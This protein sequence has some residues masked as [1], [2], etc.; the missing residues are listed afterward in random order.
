MHLEGVE[1]LAADQARAQEERTN[2]TANGAAV[3][4]VQAVT[5]EELLQR[6]I[7]M[8][9]YILNPWLREKEIGLVHAW[10]GIGKTF[11]TLNLAYAS[12]S[13]G[14]YL[15]WRA[16]RPRKVLYIDGEMPARTMQERLAAI[17]KGSETV[18]AF[19]PENL[20]FIC[21]DLQDAPLPNLSTREGQAA[22]APHVET[23]DLVIIDSI[24][25]LASY[26]EENAAE[27][28]LP[29]QAWALDLRRRGKTVVFV[30]HD[31]K[32]GQQ[33]GTSKREDILDV[34]IHLRRPSD[35]DPS[36]GARFEVH[37]AKARALY[38]QAV[39]PVEARL[40]VVN[41]QATWTMKTVA[42]ADLDRVAAILADGGKIN[43]IIEELGCSRA[44]AY[45]LKKQVLKRKKTNA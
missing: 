42:E 38:G 11:F 39:N 44:T 41:D 27:S 36:E 37:F 29:L 21:A 3:T 20:R 43:A 5:I 13:G 12:A 6:K 31:G 33:R 30:H 45:R 8:R 10:R 17:I 32:G 15:G 1:A 23:A 7:P 25:T 2:G 35:Y 16:P 24:S 34:V 9:E 26:G 18:D 28:W 14:S 40:E 4:S 19:D 22:I